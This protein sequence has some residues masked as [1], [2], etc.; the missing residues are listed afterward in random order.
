[1]SKINAFWF[2]SHVTSGSDNWGDAIN[3]WLIKKMSGCDVVKDKKG[4]RLFAIGSVLGHGVK[5]G[6]VIWGTGTL[7]S[8]LI[9]PG[10]NLDIK[11]VR[12]PL[13]RDLLIKSGYKC[14]DVYGDPAMLV[15]DFYNPEVEIT[16]DFGIIPHMSE[17]EEPA[18]LSLLKNYNVKFIDIGLG[19]T[20]FIDSLKSVR[21]IMSSSLH[22]LIMADAYDIPNT[23][24]DLPGPQWKG[25]NWKF[26][27][28][29]ASVGRPFH[30]GHMFTDGMDP[31]FILKNSHFNQSINIDLDPL[32]NAIDWDKL[33]ID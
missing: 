19:H 1:M 7:N 32:R 21:Y 16:H 4:S 20:E 29:F 2:S 23:K 13:T 12:G 31:N 6:D 25:S 9:E 3:P 27:D 11:A 8:R 15:K 28:Y 17:R 5:N 14:P 26:A 18:V 22:G 24:I 33:K 30:F 10:L